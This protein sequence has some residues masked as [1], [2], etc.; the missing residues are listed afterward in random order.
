[1]H[2]IFSKFSFFIDFSADEDRTGLEGGTDDSRGTLGEET[3]VEL[4]ADDPVI[5]ASFCSNASIEAR[6]AGVELVKLDGTC[7][8]HGIVD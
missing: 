7:N 4:T 2:S 8:Q 6:F 3:I 5:A 1:M